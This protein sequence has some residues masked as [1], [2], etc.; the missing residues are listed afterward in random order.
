[1]N[2]EGRGESTGPDFRDEFGELIQSTLEQLDGSNEAAGSIPTGF[3][4]LDEVTTG[5]PRGSLTVI[6]SHPGVGSSTLALGIARSTAIRHGIPAAY[7]TLDD[8]AERITQRVL[9]AEAK[10]K[11]YDLRS[12]RMSDDDWTRLARRTQE[13]L[14]CPLVITRPESRE[15]T[16][17]VDQIGDLVTHQQARLVVVDSLHLVTARSALPYENRE[18][19]V[20]EVTRVLKQVAL[21]NDIAVVTTA[22]LSANPGPRMPSPS[23]PTLADLRDSGTVAHVADYV[24]LLYRPDAWDRDDPRGGEVDL[25]LA[26]NRHGPPCTCTVAHQLHLS[27]FVD[28]A[29]G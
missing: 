27:R 16:T 2:R 5:L 24:V 14:E 18:R 29:R 19:E 25:I 23:A 20:A 15:I 21:D 22:Q 12:Q 10:I 4:E 8:T 11:L 1:M 13:I 7:L 26:K 3:A 17:L 9:S 28:M 6:G